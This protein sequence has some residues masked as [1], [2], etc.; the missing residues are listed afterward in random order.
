MLEQLEQIQEALNI[1]REEATK[2]T[3]KGNKSA[4]TRV[5]KQMQEIKAIAQAVRTAV[6]EANKA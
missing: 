4:G 1:A 3:E 2:F 6:S 5:R